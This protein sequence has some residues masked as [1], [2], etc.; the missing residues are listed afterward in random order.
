MKALANNITN[1]ILVTASGAKCDAKRIVQSF[2]RAAM[3]SKRKR[4]GVRDTGEVEFRRA[5]WTLLYWSYAWRS[6][7]AV[8]LSFNPSCSGVGV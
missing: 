7:D 3:Q 5:W 6:S 2:E 8:R 1:A 4:A